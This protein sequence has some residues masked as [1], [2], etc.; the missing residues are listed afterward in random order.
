MINRDGEPDFIAER[1]ANNQELTFDI[2]KTLYINHGFNINEKTFEKNIGLFTSDGKYNK[3]AELLADNNDLEIVV[4][5]FAGNDKSVMLKRTVYGKRSLLQCTQ[6]VLDYFDVI[7]ETKVKV[8]GLRRQE[9]KYF[10]A[11]VAKEAWLNAIVHTRWI[12]N[13]APV[14]CIFDDHIEI[15]SNGG[16]PSALT[17]ED[18][19]KGVSKPVN[20]KLLKI[21][22]DLDYIEEIGH[23]VPKI[24]EKYGKEI[25]YISKHTIRVSIPL[26]KELLEN[27]DN[28]DNKVLSQSEIKVIKYVENN[29]KSTIAKIAKNIKLSE[30][31]VGK[32]LVSLKK[33]GYIK[34]IGAN[35]NGYYEVIK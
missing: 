31:Y 23:G 34:H 4:A 16:L 3:M 18:F 1:P 28:F 17:E 8:G 15:D 21:F 5:T 11:D 6:N 7:N 32:I 10:D 29:T 35:K 9:E 13:I 14:V 12:E 30:S 22:K 33:N 27:I 2:L 25:F 26:N 24:I 19:Y 20:L